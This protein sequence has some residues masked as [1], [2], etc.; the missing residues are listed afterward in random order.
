MRIAYV[1]ADLGVPVF[2]RKGC[3][4][5]VQ[6]VI[7]ALT[8]QG[9]EVELEDCFPNLAELETALLRLGHRTKR[10]EKVAGGMN[11]VLLDA[12][13]LIHGAACWRADGVPIGLSGGP[14]RDLG[15]ADQPPGPRL[16]ALPVW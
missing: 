12:A 8:A 15:G 3:S 16:S 5:H 13:G 11:G 4:I 6:E 2:G 7:R 9:A 14:A 10:V 1:S